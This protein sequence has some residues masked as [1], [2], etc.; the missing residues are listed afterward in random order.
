MAGEVSRHSAADS[1]NEVVIF[2]NHPR[3]ILNHLF[4]N[5]PLASNTNR[6]AL[7]NMALTIIQICRTLSGGGRILFYL[8]ENGFVREFQW[9]RLGT[10]LA[11]G[12]ILN[13]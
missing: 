1:R 9:P 5:Q 4:D 6:K 12:L 8:G 7:E 11:A 2:H 10:I 13:H 3:N